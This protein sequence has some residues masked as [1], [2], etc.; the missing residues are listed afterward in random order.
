MTVD[1]IGGASNWTDEEKHAW[2]HLVLNTYILSLQAQVKALNASVE[3][4][5]TALSHIGV[6]KP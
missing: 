5:E 3:A 4:I 1:K 2:Q 6:P